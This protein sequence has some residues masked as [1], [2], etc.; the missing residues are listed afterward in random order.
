MIRN[1]SVRRKLEGGSSSDL[2]LITS[3]KTLREWK[4]CLFLPFCAAKTAK[5]WAT[6]MATPR[7]TR[8]TLAR[9]ATPVAERERPVPRR[10][11]LDPG[12]GVP[13]SFK[14]GATAFMEVFTD[15]FGPT[16]KSLHSEPLRVLLQFTDFHTQAP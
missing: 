12:L 3:M 11:A 7:S 14:V 2:G 4:R 8:G 13:G 10:Q 16:A 1:N 5:R 9:M 15:D 6:L